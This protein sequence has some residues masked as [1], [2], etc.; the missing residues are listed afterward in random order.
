MTSS[1][2]GA[3]AVGLLDKVPDQRARCLFIAHGVAHGD[4]VALPHSVH[5]EGA[6]VVGSKNPLSPSTHGSSKCER[7]R[8]KGCSADAGCC[9]PLLLNCS[10]RFM[11]TRYS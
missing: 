8:C 2:T 5:D 11:N 6:F 10:G 7:A 1:G 3:G 9:V 4:P